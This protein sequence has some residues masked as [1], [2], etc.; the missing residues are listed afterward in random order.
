LHIGQTLEGSSLFLSILAI[1]GISF[2]TSPK[3]MSLGNVRNI[4]PKLIHKQ[5]RNYFVNDAF[6]SIFAKTLNRA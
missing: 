2:F 3:S 6:S 5:A 1:A 4:N